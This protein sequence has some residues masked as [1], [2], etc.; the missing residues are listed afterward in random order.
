MLPLS[1]IFLNV[2]KISKNHLHVDLH[3]PSV[4]ARFHSKQTFFLAYTEKTKNAPR[5]GLFWY[6]FSF[7]HRTHKK[8]VFLE[9]TL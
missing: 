5:K 3:I 7:L 1:R 4:H 6:L 8:S 2:K 9:T